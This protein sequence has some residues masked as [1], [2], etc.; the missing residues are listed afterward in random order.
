MAFATAHIWVA[1]AKYRSDPERFSEYR[2]SVLAACSLSVADVRTFVDQNKDRPE[3][4][5]PYSK[6][7]KQFVDS[8]LEIEDSLSA[9][10]KDSLRQVDPTIP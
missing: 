1:S 9:A 7:L 5:Y 6:Q 8:L 4:F 2:D 10:L 3:K